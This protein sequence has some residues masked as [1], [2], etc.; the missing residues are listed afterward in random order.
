MNSDEATPP[1]ALPEDIAT[2]DR[3]AA[4]SRPT[5]ENGLVE[6]LTEVVTDAGSATEPAKPSRSFI[7]SPTGLLLALASVAVIIYGMR[8]AAG[9]LNPILLALFLVMGISPFIH[10]LRR[11]GLPPWATLA[12]VLVLF[13]V[14]LLLFLAIAAG[15]LSQL[16]DKLPVYKENLSEMLADVEVWF[17]ERGIDISGLTSGTLEPENAIEFSGTLIKGAINALTNIGLMIFIVLFMIG[18]VF[19]FPRKLTDKVKLSANFR[20]SLD[21]FGET[22]RG[23]LFTKAWLAAI[24]TVIV[25][26]IYY[27]F[28]TDFA[29]LW[30]LLFFVMSFVP[31][32]GFVLAVI[33]PFMVTLLESGFWTAVV[34]L[35]LTIIFNT[36]VDS[37]MGPHFMSKS[38]GLTSLMC[39][40]SL[41]IWGWVLGGVGALISVPMTLMVKLLFFDSYEST[42]PISEFM[43]KS[44]LEEHR[45]RRRR[46]KAEKAA[47]EGSG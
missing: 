22:T 8:Y 11:K 41:I 36:I 13:V 4:E 2:E 44:P 6:A 7:G 19:S 42:R 31:N 29:L 3:P 24:M 14:I 34:V 33:P 21:N 10:W 18:E 37:L 16:D 39:F 26:I 9:I 15:S 28:G 12:V 27:A 25:A 47:A 5:E 23:Y 45:K 35:L 43:A 38:V 20:R 1:H 46:K 40:L 30:A 32:I 17:S